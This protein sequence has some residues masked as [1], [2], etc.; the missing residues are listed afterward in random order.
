MYEIEYPVKQS[1][2]EIEA[3]LFYKLDSIGIDARLQVTAFN[4]KTEKK[5][6]KLDLV[7]FAE[8][9]AVCIV[10]CKSWTDGYNKNA[11]YRTNNSK[12]IRKYKAIYGLPV[13]IC[14]R[15]EYIP[16]IVKKVKVIISDFSKKE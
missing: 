12:Q 9:K 15:E 13:L 7:V 3:I 10:E 2:A 16:E 14:A 6:C 1:E 4:P 5:S 8:K 11:I